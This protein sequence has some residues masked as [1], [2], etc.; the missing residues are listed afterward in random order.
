MCH[1]CV[2]WSKSKEK[3][4]LLLCK[5]ELF[6]FCWLASPLL[7]TTSFG[8][9]D[10]IFRIIIVLVRLSLN[11]LS[12]NDMWHYC[13]CHMNLPLWDKGDGALDRVAVRIMN[14]FTSPLL[15]M[16][17]MALMGSGR[18][19]GTMPESIKTAYVYVCASEWTHMCVLVCLWIFR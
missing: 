18:W 6:C 10:K 3:T 1:H 9:Y 15:P 8:L 4:R 5:R 19:V 17:R 12:R 11:I 16:S 2:Q 14:P 13:A 7:L